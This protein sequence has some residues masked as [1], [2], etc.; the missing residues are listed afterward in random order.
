MNSSRRLP[1]AQAQ[2]FVIEACNQPLL[3]HVGCGWMMPCIQ[4]VAT[5]AVGLDEFRQHCQ[6]V[7]Q[8]LLRRCAEF[9]EGKGIPARRL[10]SLKAAANL[11]KDPLQGYNI[12][13]YWNLHL[14]HQEDPRGMSLWFQALKLSTGPAH[15]SSQ[16]WTARRAA[17]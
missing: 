4:P 12:G 1:K 15:R 13:T 6:L 5:V 7:E 11:A 17:A 14:L 2:L 3:I 10:G 16:T 9:Y 8:L